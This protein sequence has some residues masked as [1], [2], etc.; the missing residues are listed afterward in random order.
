MAL[1]FTKA[2]LWDNDLFGI[3]FGTNDL[4]KLLFLSDKKAKLYCVLYK[5][6]IEQLLM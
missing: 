2:S 5:T 3:F 6:H 4:S 1:N